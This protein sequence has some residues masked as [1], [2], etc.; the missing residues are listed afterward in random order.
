MRGK[1]NE[2]TSIRTCHVSLNDRYENSFQ[3]DG[4]RHVPG[5]DKE[6]KGRRSGSSDKYDARFRRLKITSRWWPLDICDYS[7]RI[8]VA[9]V[10]N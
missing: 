7:H 6:D 3:T 1:L 10:E 4:K 2:V 5:R 8:S 9:V